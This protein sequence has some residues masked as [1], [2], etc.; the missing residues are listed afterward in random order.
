MSKRRN[1]I[2]FIIL[3]SVFTFGSVLHASPEVIGVSNGVNQGKNVVNGIVTDELGPVAGASV[4]IKGTTHGTITDLDGKFKLSVPDGA[5]ILISFIGYTPQTIEYKGEATINVKLVTDSKAIDEV[6]VTALGIK[7]DAKKLGYAVSTISADQ[8]IKTGT[9]NFATSLYGKAAG[10]RIQAAPGGSTSAVSIN[11][12]GISSIT[13]TNQPLLIIDG[14]PVRNGDANTSGYW[15]NQRVS[16]NGL[17]DVNPE[18]IENLSIL[19]GASAS[20]LY[21]SEAANG[22]VLITTKSGKGSKGLGVDFNATFSVDKVAYMPELQTTFGPGNAH[23][24]VTGDWWDN[25]GF[26]KETYK[27]TEYMR[28]QYEHTRQFGP[29]YDGRDVIYWDGSV[30]KYEANEGNQW[31][32]LFRLGFNQNYNLS[33]V[34]GS[35]NSNLRFSYTYTDELNVQR[36]SKNNKHNFSLSGST[37]VSKNFKVDYTANY[38]RRNINNRP[39][40]ISRITNN[41]GGMFGSFDDTA[42]MWDKTTTSLGYLNV[43]GSAQTPTPDESILFNGVGSWSG[44]VGEYFWNIKGKE[45]IEDNNRFMASVTPTINIVDGLTLRGRLSTDLTVENI[46]NM[47]KSEKPLAFG[48]T[49]GYSI[50]N[51][52]YEIYY[53]DVLLMYDKKLTDKIGLMANVGYQARNESVYQ[54]SAS[55]DGGLSVENWFHL[56]A[57]T[58]TKN[59]SMYKSDYVKQALLGMMTLSYDD[60]L[61]LEGTIRQEKSSTMPTGN[62]SFVYPSANASFIYTQALRKYL[63]DWYNYGKVRASWG[64][65]GNAAAIYQANFAYNQNSLSGFIYNEVPGNLG[66]EKIRPEEKHEIE[67]GIENKMF[68]NRLGFEVSYYTNTVK[69]QILKTTT[70]TSSGANSILQNVGELKNSGLEVSMFGTP[71]ETKDWRL[72]L[73]GNVSF[74]KN[75][76]TKLM[77]GV[78]ELEHRNIDGAVTVVSRVGEPMGDIYSFVAKTDAAGNKIV[79][80]SGLYSVDYSKRVKVGNAMP[81]VVG[82]FGTSLSYKNLFFDATL[83]FRVGGAVLNTPYQYMMGRGNLI[84][85][86][87]YRGLENGGL[88]YYYTGNVPTGDKMPVTGTSGPNGERVYEDGLIL[89]GVKADGTK[90]DKMVSSEVYYTSTYNWGASGNVDYS[91]SIFE[92]TFV[93]VRELSLGYSFPK[94]IAKQLKCNNFTVSVFGRNLFYLYKNLPAFDAEATDGTNWISQTDIGGSTAT[95]RSFGLSLRASF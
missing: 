2:C 28:P 67:F 44:L 55:T 10:V 51:R 35:E 17:V 32:N 6:V 23:E 92:N 7:K 56:N 50:S 5:T 88:A 26:R 18:D 49:G 61:F 36:N 24:W 87:K 86:L 21:G 64:I 52:R 68:N 79:D 4:S 62:N 15:D 13:G 66:N 84:E 81:K 12:R 78:D 80:E 94:K 53:G 34:K 93:K 40:R 16:S 43:V 46:E 82:G 95:T 37:T 85:S 42:L 25:G 54:V 71:I 20:A 91:N 77:D 9:P 33:I 76:V 41:F 1:L 39:Y 45:Q 47:N 3:A 69:D 30:R 22:V 27:G 72:E 59:T 8:L 60:Y 70:P 48:P 29:R 83:D 19:K 63:P 89:P 65:V 90:N 14:V 73:R 11:I 74:N 38:L 57:S 58:K 31:N 75:T